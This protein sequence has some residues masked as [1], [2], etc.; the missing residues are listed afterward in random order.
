MLAIFK[1]EFKSYFQN[2][3][4]W[5]FVAAVL[6]V[7]GLYFYV[8]NLTNGYPYLSYSLSSIAFIMVI[9]VPI[10]TMRCF[11]EDRKNKVDQL[12]LTAPVSVGKIV[13]GKFFAM[14]AVFT[15]D[16][17]AICLAPLVLSRFGTVPFGEC[18]ISILGFWLFGCAMIAIGMFLSSITESQVIAAVISFAVLFVGYMMKSIE[19]LVSSSGNMV[20]KI[21]SAF[22]LYSPFDG[23]NSGCLNLTGVAYYLTVI[24]LLS[25]LTTQSIQKRR[26]SISSK[27]IST[28]VFSAGLVVIAIVVSVVFNMFVNTLPSSVTSL[29]FSYAKLY[30]LTDD[31]KDFMKSLDQ[32]V[33][34]Y[35]LSKE[36]SKDDQLDETLTRYEDLSKHV[37]VKYINPSTNPYFYKDYTDKAPTTNSLIV[38]GTDRSR[39]VDFNDIYD[40]QTSM[41]YSTYSYNQELKGYDAE[42]QITSAI[43]YVT[44]SADQLPVV[45]QITGHGETELSSAFTSAL[46]KA[47]ITLD[48][49]ELLKQD[50][51]P[52][53][54]QAIIINA[55]TSDFNAD[56]AQKVIDY[57]QNGGKAMIAG[58]YGYQD[59]TNFNSI[60]AAYNVSFVDG[61]VGENDS[62]YYYNNNPFYLLPK[63]DSSDYTS[64]VAN[65]YI[66]A[67]VSEGISYPDSTDDVT[68]TPL[69]ETTDSAVSKTSTDEITTAAFED[70]DVQGPFAVALAIEQT[71]DD[72]KQT[73]IAV[74]GSALF[75]SDECDQVVSGNNS[76]MFTG[77][78]SNMVGDTELKAGVI[79]EKEY[80]LSNLTVATLSAVALGLCIAI[81]IPIILIVCG[82]VIWAVRRKK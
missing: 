19:G 23:F 78:I 65:S 57:L 69:L 9:A 53:D 66:F 21:M 24:L 11:S 50:A 35:V 2:V 6:A 32:D 40:Y 12:V 13:M 36:S 33:T 22:D 15:I 61:V 74:L 25:F 63:V 67:P 47:N 70:G 39:V 4:G 58:N 45:Y 71:V 62:N 75:L 44:M 77:M 51:V 59:L 48:S 41:D 80:T 72:D 34:I 46:E 8:Y 14:A 1:R 30:A 55:P 10:L 3:I 56:D 28:G 20:T 68:Y 27:K 7:F 5:L 49:L 76:A 31:T 79:P 42:G 64:S 37:T 81:F 54:A 29:D 38:A 26:W 82:I 73:Q 52:S 17:A 43:E 18:Y 60:L 16:V